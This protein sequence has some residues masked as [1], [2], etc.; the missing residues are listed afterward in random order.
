MTFGIFVSN[1]EAIR[2]AMQ[3]WL[4]AASMFIRRSAEP[5]PKRPS[6]VTKQ[7]TS[8]GLLIAR[9][10]VAVNSEFMADFSQK[11]W[12]RQVNAAMVRI[13]LDSSGRQQ[14]PS[15]NVPRDWV[16][17]GAE[18]QFFA[19]LRNYPCTRS[20]NPCVQPATGTRWSYTGIAYNPH[21]SAR[22]LCC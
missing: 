21:S 8:T 14:S 5:I 7:L 20:N 3:Y 12:P 15:R 17:I 1:N 22:I 6:R 13:Q 2:G 10:Q 11:S 9:D 4:H 16:A 18:L 19:K